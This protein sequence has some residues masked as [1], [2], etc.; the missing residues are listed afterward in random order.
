MPLQG[1]ASV[2]DGKAFSEGDPRSHFTDSCSEN[3]SAI[4][5]IT[6]SNLVVESETTECS[7]DDEFH[8]VVVAIS[9]E[10]YKCDFS[11]LAKVLVPKSNYGIAN[12]SRGPPHA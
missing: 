7:L 6:V 1:F 12:P 9:S 4:P 8:S 2:E 11:F 3:C 10:D 5:E